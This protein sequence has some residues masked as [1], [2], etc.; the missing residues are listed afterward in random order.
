M[1]KK[2][3]RIL[4]ILIIVAALAAVYMGVID[5]LHVTPKADNGRIRV[6]CVGDS[7]TYGCFCAG[8]PWNSYPS[9][10]G[11]LLGD[12]Y[13]VVNYG[14]MLCVPMMTLHV[15]NRT[16]TKS[17][18]HPYTAE[19]LYLKSMEFRPDIVLIMLGTNDTKPYNWDPEAYK[20]DMIDMIDSYR[21][22]DPQ[23]QVFIMLPPP[24]FEVRG[25]V[26][27]DIRADVL[28]NELLPI[29]R[30]IADENGVPLID[31]YSPFLE[32]SKLFIDG[33]H[34]TPDGAGLLARTVYDAIENES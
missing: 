1:L 22:L 15:I 20:R 34:P 10:L 24:A 31:T 16:L 3:V 2:I 8:Q 21:S 13:Q 29:L 6:A 27:W 11:R 9:Q 19:E 17:G 23:P 25:K 12:A 32:Q 33:V 14:A 18:D 26:M 7:I 28:E 30:E 4:L 5:Q